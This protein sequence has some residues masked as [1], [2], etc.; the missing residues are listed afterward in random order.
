MGDKGV[1][2]RN[3]ACAEWDCPWPIW[4]DARMRVRISYPWSLQ[5]M[6]PYARI[7][8]RNQNVTVCSGSTQGHKNQRN[9]GQHEP[10][11]SWWPYSLM[12]VVL[13]TWSSFQIEHTIIANTYCV[14]SEPASSALTLFCC[15][16]MLV[17]HVAIWTQK[18]LNSFGWE[19]LDHPAHSP[20]LNPCDF[21]I[22]GPL[23]KYLRGRY[24]ASGTDLQAAVTEWFASQPKEGFYQGIHYL[25][26]K[27]G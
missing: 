21:H 2:Q 15:T 14:V 27:W 18:L 22:F 19:V 5:E 3:T 7:T 12:T 24:Y 17:P 1:C 11:R 13:C 8:N 10:A 25:V 23:T 4:C 20:G 6:N 16:V 9:V 26:S